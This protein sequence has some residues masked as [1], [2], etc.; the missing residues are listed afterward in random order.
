MVFVE[1]RRAVPRLQL[2]RANLRRADAS[3]CC[4]RRSKVAYRISASEA[5]ARLTIV[6]PDNT[7][8]CGR[9]RRAVYPPQLVSRSPVQ[10]AHFQVGIDRPFF[11]IAGPC[12]IEGETLTQEI[13]GQPQ[14]NHH[15]A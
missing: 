5:S 10:L 4:R 14:G 3:R 7:R 11:L 6:A 8:S 1:S 9:T 13:A 15:A 2:R 12:V